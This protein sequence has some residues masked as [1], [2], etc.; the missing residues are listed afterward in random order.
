MAKYLRRYP[1]STKSDSAT[2]SARR[3]ACA[4]N[5][6]IA[7]RALVSPVLGPHATHQR[8]K[9]WKKYREHSTTVMLKVHL[10]YMH[11]RWP[12]EAS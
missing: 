10:A 3:L 5:G 9:S 7:N 1:S 2:I 4:A 11:T 8:P 6:K 12:S